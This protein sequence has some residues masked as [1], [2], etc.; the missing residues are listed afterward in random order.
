EERGL[1]GELRGPEDS[2]VA[3]LERAR[4]VVCQ[5]YRRQQE[6]L[7]GSQKV[8][9]VLARA[10]FRLGGFFVPHQGIGDKGQA[11]VEQKQ[12]E[13]VGGECHAQGRAERQREAG[14]IA[15][16]RVLLQGAHVADRVKRGQD[17]EQGCSG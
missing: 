15:S 11:F 4:G 7:G 5:D 9:D 14:E 6:D 2:A 10:G 13:Q 8:D 16:L 3:K 17:P 1:R 12:G